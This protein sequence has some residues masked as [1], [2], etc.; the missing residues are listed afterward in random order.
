MLWQAR[1]WL[2]LLGMLG[3]V[4]QGQ[5]VVFGVIG[6]YGTGGAAAGQVA[7]LVKSWAP[8]LIITVGDNDYTNANDIDGAIG[9][10]YHPYIYNYRGSYGVGSD[11]RRFFPTWGNHEYYPGLQPYQD[12]FDLPGNE[13]YYRFRQGPV[14]F[15]ALNSNTAEPDGIGGS[16]VQAQWLRAALADSTA[17]WKVVYFH[18][19]PY[20]SRGYHGPTAA[21]RWPFEQWGADVVLSGHEHFYERLRSGGLNYLINGA[22]GGGRYPLSSI[23]PESQ[24]RYNA[25]YGAL[26]AQADPA[27]LRFQFIT[28]AGQVIDDYLICRGALSLDAQAG[29]APFQ[30]TAEVKAGGV[31]SINAEQHLAG[32]TIAGGRVSLGPGVQA[33]VTRALVMDEQGTLD[34][35]EQA[36]IVEAAGQE[37]SIARQLAAWVGRARQQ[38]WTGPGI[39]S[40]L[41]S[42]WDPEVWGV[43]VVPNQAALR[44]R[45]AGQDV[46]ASSILVQLARNGDT[47]L[48]GVIDA[49]DYFRLYRGLERHLAG[50]HNGDFNYDTVIDLGDLLLID[51]GYLSQ[52]PQPGKALAAALPEPGALLW[53]AAA[54]ALW[55]RRRA[56]HGDRPRG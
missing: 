54:G 10:F 43:A 4:A 44:Q 52:F 25:D 56:A 28:R 19:P 17:P 11:T 27:S 46:T 39:T 13:R 49:D 5:S 38:N 50:Y 42:S 34:L 36:L 22:G 48:S 53:L 18:H 15:F 55:P 9:Q 7:D 30:L 16:S 8:D 12:Y 20:A 21:M 3:G 24:L 26:K 29:D 31:L 47:D 41:L 6:D 51:R 45:F 37:A 40:S 2:G 35:A 14:E 23:A 32:L 1:W 33:L